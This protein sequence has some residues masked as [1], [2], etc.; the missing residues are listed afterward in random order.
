MYVCSCQNVL[1]RLTDRVWVVCPQYRVLHP[2]YSGVWECLW[3]KVWNNLK[4]LKRFAFQCMK[5]LKW[6]FVK[7]KKVW[8]LIKIWTLTS[9]SIAVTNTNIPFTHRHIHIHCTFSVEGYYMCVCVFYV[10]YAALSTSI[11][12]STQIQQKTQNTFYF[13]NE[14]I[15][16]YVSYINE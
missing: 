16:L 2:Q 13:S 7:S 1:P 3:E 12:S 4:C 8:N 14:Y 10:C 15:Y 11:S 5:S 6:G 9:L